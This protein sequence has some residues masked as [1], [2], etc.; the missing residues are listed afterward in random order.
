MTDANVLA[1][2]AGFGNRVRLRRSETIAAP[3]TWGIF[4]PIILVPAGFE[5]LPAETRE[6]VLC[7]EYAHIQGGDFLMRLLAETARALIWFQ[8]LIWIVRRQLREEQELACDNRVL[9]SGRKPSAYAKLLLDWD[10]GRGMDSSIAL[11]MTHRSCLKR[12]LYALL[13]PNL[14]RDTV[15][16][17]VAACTWVFGLATAMALAALGFAEAIPAPNAQTAPAPQA[18]PAPASRPKFDSASIQPCQPG[19]GPGRSGRGDMGANGGVDPSV[20]E[21]AGGYFRASPGRLDVSCGSILTMVDFSYREFGGPLLNN[22]PAPLQESDRIKG[23]PKWA[24]ATRY[25]IHAVTGDPAANG[26]T[27]AGPRQPSPLP[28]AKLLYGP[29]LRT[30]LE[31]RFQLKMHREVEQAQM[32]AL[33]V[34]QSGFK[35]RPMQDGECTLIAPGQG[36]RMI[37]ADDKALLSLGW[38]AN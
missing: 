21:G 18:A 23:V 24:L 30:L 7:H 37:G 34:A 29:M 35:L 28:A 27:D 4:R 20:P 10:G 9:A 14:R 36:I 11:G 22:P 2:V 15:T 25:T 31:D 8:P 13:D 1:G 26:P 12:R 19:D 17:A 38:M 33:T 16:G 3:V 6:A 32:Y 5:E